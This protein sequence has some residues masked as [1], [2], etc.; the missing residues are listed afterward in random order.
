VRAWA[1]VL[2]DFAPDE[3]RLAIARK[4][5][6]LDAGSPE[7]RR[8]KRRYVG[9]PE[10]FPALMP[11]WLALSAVYQEQRR[12]ADAPAAARLRQ[13]LAEVRPRLLQGGGADGALPDGVERRPQPAGLD[14]SAHWR[15]LGGSRR[16]AALTA[17]RRLFV[18]RCAAWGL[19]PDAE[20]TTAIRLGF[21]ADWAARQ[22]P[23]GRS[24]ELGL[25]A[26]RS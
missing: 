13:R 14:R 16:A 23:P 3:V 20:E 1:D 7:E 10:R 12:A 26:V 19:D 6:S 9:R 2:A 15:Q 11:A 5:A 24:D 18:E 8:R 22:W 17:T 4:A 25:E 21:A